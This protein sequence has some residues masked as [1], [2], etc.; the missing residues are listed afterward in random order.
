[1][2]TKGRVDKGSKR[3]RN[4]L[5]VGA[6]LRCHIFWICNMSYILFLGDGVMSVL[7]F[8]GQNE[9]RSIVGLRLAR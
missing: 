4:E 9:K 5:D 2:R 6:I 7:Y 1:M 3:A 8:D